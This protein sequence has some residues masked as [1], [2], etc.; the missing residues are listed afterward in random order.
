MNGEPVLCVD[1]DDPVV[2]VEPC[3]VPDRRA[4]DGEDAADAGSPLGVQLEGCEG[5][6]IGS[7]NEGML[8]KIALRLGS[9]LVR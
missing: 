6:A 4:V 9:L 1:T 5:P 2:E 3:E 8:P 7:S